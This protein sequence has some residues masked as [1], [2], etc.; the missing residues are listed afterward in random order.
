MFGMTTNEMMVYRELSQHHATNTITPIIIEESEFVAPLIEG[1]KSKRPKPDMEHVK[2][3]VADIGSIITLTTT[4][5]AYEY[6]YMQAEAN[7]EE[8]DII[9]QLH[10]KYETYL[11]DQFIGYG[12]TFGVKAITRIIGEVIIELPYIYSTAIEDGKFD[13]DTFLEENM[14][15]YEKYLGENFPD[16]VEEKDDEENDE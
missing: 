16:Y 5:M 7:T 4:H 3:V 11:I 1:N 2:Q 13:S 6:A 10:T 8:T 12:I 14:E 9:A 15:A